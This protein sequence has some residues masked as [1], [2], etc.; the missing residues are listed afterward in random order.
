GGER[1]VVDVTQDSRRVAP[2]ALFV[3]RGGQASDGRRFIADALD[4]GAAA[5]LC[6]P[7]GVDVVPRLE[8]ADLALAW[9]LTAHEVHGRPSRDVPVIGLAGTN[10]KTTVAVLIDRAPPER[11]RPPARPGTPGSSTAQEQRAR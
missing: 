9:A 3:A 8:A 7:G 4:Q 5:V 10:G 11:E 6:E 2:G 1:V